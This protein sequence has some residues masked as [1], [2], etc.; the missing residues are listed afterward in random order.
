MCSLR[1]E[2][3]RRVGLR[4]E[5]ELEDELEREVRREMADWDFIRRQRPRVR[6]ALE[7]YVETGDL[8]LAQRVAGMGLEEFYELVKRARIPIVVVRG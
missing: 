1:G 8:R 2:A 7:L 6:A 4:R 5:H 3:A